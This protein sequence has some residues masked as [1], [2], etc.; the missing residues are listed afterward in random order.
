MSGCL[1]IMHLRTQVRKK[2]GSRPRFTGFLSHHRSS[3][4]YFGRRRNPKLSSIDH[5]SSPEACTADSS[6]PMLSHAGR[7]RVEGRVGSVHIERIWVGSLARAFQV[8]TLFRLSP[9]NLQEY[10]LH[11]EVVPESSQ[12]GPSGPVRSIAHIVS[13]IGISAASGNI[14]VLAAQCGTYM[15]KK[16]RFSFLCAS[17][18]LLNGVKQKFLCQSVSTRLI[19][20]CAASGAMIFEACCA[21]WGRGTVRKVKDCQTDVERVGS[22][23]FKTQYFSPDQ[24]LA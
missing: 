10:M 23:S 24:S 5:P 7:L 19:R 18:F 3:R 1:R 6:P 17:L 13:F 11:D 9:S 22:G 14:F 20:S 2:R 8:I 12:S 15:W 21:S 16:P 4:A